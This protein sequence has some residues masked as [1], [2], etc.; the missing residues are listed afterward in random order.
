M[1]TIGKRTISAIIALVL[2]FAQ[3]PMTAMGATTY[4]ET[5]EELLED[6]EKSK[7]EEAKKP[8]YDNFMPLK[9]T[10]DV[11]IRIPGDKQGF[12]FKL[13]NV[14]DTYVQSL[15]TA[16]GYDY[17]FY[18]KNG[19]AVTVN[20]QITFK[21][22]FSDKSMW[23]K[24]D[25]ITREFNSGERNN[26]LLSGME[27]GYSMRA[28]L[29]SEVR[30]YFAVFNDSKYNETGSVYR[31]LIGDAYDS[32]SGYVSLGYASQIKPISEIV[33]DEP[34]VAETDKPIKPVKYGRDPND[35]YERFVTDGEYF[36]YINYGNALGR[37]TIDKQ[38]VS[39]GAVTTL[40]DSDTQINSINLA[41]GWI[42]FTKDEAHYSISLSGDD[43]VK[44]ADISID[45][46]VYRVRTDGTGLT[47]LYTAWESTQKRLV[48]YY[49]LLVIDDKIYIDTK[50]QWLSMN[51]DGSN[52]RKLADLSISWNGGMTAYGS[53]IFGF[54]GL[55][56]ENGREYLRFICYDIESSAFK[57]ITTSADLLDGLIYSNLETSNGRLYFHGS[58]TFNN[59]VSPKFL[60]CKIDGTDMRE[61]YER[62]DSNYTIVGDYIFYYDVEDG[63][64][65]RASLSGSEVPVKV[66]DSPASKG[67]C[68]HNGYIYTYYFT[69]G[70]DNERSK[71]TAVI[72]K[73][74]P[75]AEESIIAAPA[76]ATVKINSSDVHFDAYAIK[77]NH[78]FKLRDIAY[79]L[80]GTEKQ[81][82][83]GWDGEHIVLISGKP[84]IAVGGE[85]VDSGAGIKTATPTK[86]K[87]YLNGEKISFIT[88]NIGGSNYVKLRDV[89][90]ALDFSLNWDGL[91][92]VIV[93]DTSKGYTE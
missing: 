63:N 56:E 86:S 90:Q 26:L 78:Y 71:H 89:G 14:Y 59:P 22:S 57:T 20:K 25:E 2:F 62:Y 7:A 75:V 48:N 84:Y 81:F 46:G 76:T 50:D 65:Y 79:A 34:F 39:G 83:A 82:E 85:M 60:S 11:T 44:T 30:V 73:V 8:K 1:S 45:G 66:I 29:D 12:V 38:S 21:V 92:S 13:E 70:Q 68:Y 67:F 51:L 33:T 28:N 87:I 40:Y 69:D 93:V 58:P 9:N 27:L 88:Y 74:D 52:P 10:R 24:D 15:A 80:N 4:Y 47:R 55:F 43:G 17:Y 49:N 35:E 77:G 72:Y 41:D 64:I 23:L 6:I 36:Y 37:K 32:E 42:Y 3:I 31:E 18:F 19:G 91:R 54:G 5:T 53:Q 16:G 61:E